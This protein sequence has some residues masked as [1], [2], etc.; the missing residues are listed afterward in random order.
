MKI[1]TLKEIF[2]LLSDEDELKIID[3][4]RP[5]TSY[6]IVECISTFDELR[7]KRYLTIEVERTREYKHE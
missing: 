4:D 1:K 6:H 5:N 3:I 7:C 2:E